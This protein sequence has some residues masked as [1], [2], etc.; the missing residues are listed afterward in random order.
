MKMS[1]SD[2]V[3]VIG[4]FVS[5]ILGTISATFVQNYFQQRKIIAW[6][7]VGELNI[8]T[9]EAFSG[10]NVPIK[11]FIDNQEETSIS[12]VKIRLGNKGN[13]EIT[14]LSIQFNF[15]NN[16]NVYGGEFS[17]KLGVYRNSIK[18][19]KS[20]NSAAIDIDYI[21]KNQSFDIDFYV[22]KYIMG[23]VSADM[24][25]AGV[26]LRKTQFTQWDLITRNIL[27]ELI[28]STPFVNVIYVGIKKTIKT[29]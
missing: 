13:T 22:G 1:S 8:I 14:N 23:E 10:F 11:I 5:F 2:W 19:S 28:L 7:V 18:L 24:A 27:E 3:N 4:W 20:G 6:A 25:K 29:P 15:G 17:G 16:A 26:E 21:N 9:P 12:V